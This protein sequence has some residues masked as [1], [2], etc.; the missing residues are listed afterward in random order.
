MAEFKHPCPACGSFDNVVEVEDSKV[1]HF[2][3]LVAPSESQ[4]VILYRFACD[5]CGYR[6]RGKLH[7]W[8]KAE[9]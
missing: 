5:K 2:P 8:L 1:N 4:V 3:G 9:E 7:R 6:G